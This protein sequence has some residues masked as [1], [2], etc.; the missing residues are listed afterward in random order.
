MKYV[1]FSSSVFFELHFDP[2]CVTEDCFYV[3]LFYNGITLEFED[4]CQ[5]K[6]KCTYP[7]FVAMMNAIWYSGENADDLDKACD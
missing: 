6:A 1:L 4:F 2:G 5:N 3:I 7:E